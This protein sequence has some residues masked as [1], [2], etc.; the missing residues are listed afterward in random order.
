MPIADATSLRS[1]R[2]SLPLEGICPIV[3]TLSK[4][5]KDLDDAFTDMAAGEAL[6]E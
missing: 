1:R 2:S 3:R 4:F 5:D 6:E